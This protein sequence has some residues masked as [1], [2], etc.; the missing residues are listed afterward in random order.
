MFRRAAAMFADEADRMAVVDHDHRAV[1]VGEVADAPRL[2][3]M[4]SI[5][6]TPSVAISLKR[7]AFGLLE[8]FLQVGHVVVGVAE[9]LG[10]GEPTPS[11]IEAWFSASEM[12][13]S[14][15]PSSVSK[16]PPLASKQAV[17]DGVLHARESARAAFELLVLLLRA[18]DEAH[19]R[20]AVAVAVERLLGGLGNSSLSARPR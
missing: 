14:S 15:S 17:E 20:H 4:P 1:F 10:L 9:A 18:A 6:N 3:M 7:A 11:M 19:R 16:R 8:F 2:A 5:E 12:T 13:A